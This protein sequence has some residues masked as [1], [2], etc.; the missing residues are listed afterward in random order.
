MAQ[1]RATDT[2]ALKLID[3][4]KGH[5]GLSRFDD[6]IATA[7]CDNWFAVFLGNRD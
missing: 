5:F 3:N 7:A 2:V 4:C 1:E 6:D